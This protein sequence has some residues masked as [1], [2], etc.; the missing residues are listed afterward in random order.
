MH[1]YI[2][3]LCV[4]IYIYICISQ[5]FSTKHQLSAEELMFLNC[6]AGEDS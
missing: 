3:N 4:F 1:V 6:G 5:F 2:L